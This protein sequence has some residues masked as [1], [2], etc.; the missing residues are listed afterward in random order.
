[1]NS[2]KIVV[3]GK[4][5]T[6]H[7]VRGWLKLHT[8]TQQASSIPQY[9]KLF[10]LRRDVWEPIDRTAVTIDLSDSGHLRIKFPDCDTPEA[11]RLY[12]NLLIG[13]TRDQL[14][15]LAAGDYYWSDLEGLAVVNKE[16]VPFGQIDHLFS[17]G[18][19]DVM[20]VKGDRERLLPYTKDVVLE[21]D[22]EKGEMKVD[23][24][25]EF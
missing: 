11:A 14:P 15:A 7:G 12:T 4:V 8:F 3:V 19:N 23:W 17:T 10:L 6:P 25:P 21:V 13:V 9:P 18:A 24:D 22:L 5:G 1:M 2:S 20:V 16:G